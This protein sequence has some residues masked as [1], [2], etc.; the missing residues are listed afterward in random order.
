MVKCPSTF[1]HIA[2]HKY[3]QTKVL[4]SLCWLLAN[5]YA[6][7]LLLTP[8]PTS[9]IMVPY[10]IRLSLCFCKSTWITGRQAMAIRKWGIILLLFGI[11][12]GI[13]PVN[14]FSCK[15]ALLCWHIY[16]KIMCTTFSCSRVLLTFWKC[17]SWRIDV[18]SWHFVHI[19]YGKDLFSGNECKIYRTL[20][21]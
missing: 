16:I 4:P 6:E 20:T 15:E 2:P 18:P 12:N 8:K 5:L 10:N 7:T 17:L 21:G 9:G 19:C 1:G 11:F 3:S 13:W 14:H